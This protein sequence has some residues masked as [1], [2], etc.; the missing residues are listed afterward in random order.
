MFVR[1]IE[2]RSFQ[3]S[4]PK[5]ADLKA[6]YCKYRL[7]ALKEL[8]SAAA[9]EL[10]AVSAVGNATLHHWKPPSYPTAPKSYSGNAGVF[11]AINSV[12]RLS[13]RNSANSASL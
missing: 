9:E 6:R 12:N 5:G 1:E 11:I 3:V 2:L 10:E 8:K 13:L 4:A 7:G